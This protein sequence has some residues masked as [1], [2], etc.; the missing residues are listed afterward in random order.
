V[1]TWEDKVIATVR[2]AP[3]FEP[4]V[5]G[6]DV[7]LCQITLTTCY[8]YYNSVVTLSMMDRGRWKK[9]IKIG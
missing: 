7:V 5:C 6:S 3:F 4:S 8:Y 1:P 9:L 2:V